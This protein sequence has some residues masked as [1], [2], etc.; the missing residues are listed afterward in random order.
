MSGN[1]PYDR[2]S[3]A[4]DSNAMSEQAKRGS[5]I[6]FFNGRCATCHAG[7]N[8]SDGRFPQSWRRMGC[9]HAD[10]SRTKVALR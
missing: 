1:A 4:G 5:E 9:D 3:Y 7:F 8:F 10:G 6:F 2:W